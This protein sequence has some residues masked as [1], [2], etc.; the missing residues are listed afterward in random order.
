M[1]NVEVP[2]GIA[3]IAADGQLTPRQK[4]R[5]LIEMALK[6]VR[7]GTGSSHEFMRRRT[8]MYDWPDL[9]TVLQGIDWVIVGGVATRTY[10][11]E[12]MTKDLDILVRRADEEFVLERLQ[13]AGY[14]IVSELAVPGYL[15]LSPEGVE[16]DLLLGEQ[17]WLNEALANPERDPAG[18]PVLGFPYLVLMKMNTG[19]G[20]DFGDVTT[21]L[22]WANDEQ[23]Q[24]ARDVVARYSQQDSEDLESLIFL[25]QH[26]RQWPQ[27]EDQ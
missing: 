20:R 8:A 1:S 4:R 27:D 19:R 6:R 7:P 21:M 13:D 26:E 18:Y 24:A 15:L 16:I 12:R 25:G 14:K 9:R 10:M 2:S 23:L 22:G 11:P 17:P 5:L 3:S